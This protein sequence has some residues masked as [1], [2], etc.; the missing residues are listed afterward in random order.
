MS[1]LVVSAALAAAAEPS[2][3]QVVQHPQDD[4]A[5]GL[6]TRLL[7]FGYWA[8]RGATVRYN[9]D[10]GLGMS[11]VMDLALAFPGTDFT[12]AT[13]DGILANN[14]VRA[15]GGIDIAARPGLRGGYIGL[16]SGVEG[17]I[18]EERFESESLLVHFV[19]GKKW[20]AKEG[21]T[22]QVGGGVAARVPLGQGPT[23]EELSPVVELRVGLANHR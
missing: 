11:F 7:T 17:F 23:P 15:L 18:E 4:P 16:R 2:V 3:S 9:G 13:P 8:A 6:S 19:L 21:A 10:L 1:I 20:I 12:T 14:F 22:L 5:A